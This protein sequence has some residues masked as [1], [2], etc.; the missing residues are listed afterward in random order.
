M[1]GVLENGSAEQGLNHEQHSDKQEQWGATNGHGPLMS[2]GS[3]GFD[4]TNAGFPPNMGFNGTGDFGQMMQFMPSSM[5][6]NSM[7]AFPNMMG[8]SPF[9]NCFSC[10]N[11]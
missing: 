6:A 9:H 7:G 1:N 11:Y 2:N 8:K 3:F 10:S 5:Q 4:G